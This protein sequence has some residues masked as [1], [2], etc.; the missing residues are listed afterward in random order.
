MEPQRSHIMIHY[1]FPIGLSLHF[2]HP[3]RKKLASSH[4]VFLQSCGEMTEQ[5]CGIPALPNPFPIFLLCASLSRFRIPLP[6]SLTQ[7]LP[8]LDPSLT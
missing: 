1:D 5:R 7:V 8:E 4:V 3:H 2:P 6:E